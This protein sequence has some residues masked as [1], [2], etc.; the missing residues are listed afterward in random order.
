MQEDGEV[1]EMLRITYSRTYGFEGA[2]MGMRNPYDSRSKS[3]S[4]FRKEP[5]AGTYREEIG[6][7]D[8][9]LCKKL[10]IAGSD[11]RKFL[12]MIHVQMDITAPLYWWKEADTYKVGTTANSSST[13][14]TIHKKPFELSDFSCE[15][16]E[17]IAE[18]DEDFARGN[19]FKDVLRALNSLRELYLETR[20]M[21]YWYSMI[22]LLPSSY[23]QMRTL[24]ID[25]ETL[26]RIYFARKD[27]KLSEWRHFCNEI[28][29][30]PY[31]A[32]F[33]EAA[34]EKKGR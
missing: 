15:Y 29:R 17:R 26:I 23:N 33:I 7:E 22:Q 18:T 20:D 12:R 10:I 27:H 9:K 14:H 34:E 11:H 1:R 28:K 6:E 8:M 5:V 25:Y 21:D 2:I 32:E 24:D 13:M 4:V 3:D 31:L 16:I 30:L 19:A